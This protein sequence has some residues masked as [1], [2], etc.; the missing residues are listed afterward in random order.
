MNA[1][2]TAPPTGLANITQIRQVLRQLL[3]ETAT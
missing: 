3:V 2:A 1:T